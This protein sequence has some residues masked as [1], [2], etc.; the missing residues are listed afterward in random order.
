MLGKHEG[1][2]AYTVGQRARI[3]GLNAKYF[4]AEKGDENNLLV[5][6]GTKHPAL[7]SDMCFVTNKFFNWIGVPPVEL[8]RGLVCH[9]RVRHRQE[10]GTCVAF[11]IRDEKEDGGV[12]LQVNFDVPHRGVTQEQAVVLYGFNGRCYGGGP[13]SKVG[14]SYYRQNK[15]LPENIPGWHM[16]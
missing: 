5:A 7:Y 10:L 15:E 2:A 12:V 11:L 13:I 6:K 1:I 4:V 8:E 9:Y 3:G 14:P 16:T